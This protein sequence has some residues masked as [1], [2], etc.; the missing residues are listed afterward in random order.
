MAIKTNV[1]TTIEET[2]MLEKDTKLLN[3]IIEDYNLNN[4]TP[5]DLLERANRLQE[6]FTLCK[7]LE[8]IK[9]DS[10]IDNETFTKIVS[11][12]NNNEI[13]VETVT[14]YQSRI[15]EY[16]IPR[17]KYIKD[18]RKVKAL[19]SITNPS[20]RLFIVASFRNSKYI[21]EYL[22]EFPRDDDTYFVIASYTSDQDLIVDMFKKIKLSTFKNY[23][24]RN[25]DEEHKKEVL[26]NIDNINLFIGALTRIK[27]DEFKLQ[28]LKREN[29]SYQKAIRIIISIEDET[30]RRATLEKYYKI[31]GKEIYTGGYSKNYRFYLGGKDALPSSLSF[32]VELEIVGKNAGAILAY[33]GHLLGKHPVKEEESI[34]DGVEIA[35]SILHFNRQDIN[36]IYEICDFAHRNGLEVDLRC[37]G[38]IHFGIDLLNGYDAWYFLFYIYTRVEHILYLI[39]NERGDLPRDNVDAFAQPISAKY[40]G[41]LQEIRSFKTP[42]EFI[43]IIQKESEDKGEGINLN[44]IG[45]RQDTIEFR[46]PN[47][48]INPRIITENVLLFGNLIVLASKLSRL[49]LDANTYTLLMELDDDAKSE[50]ERLDVLLK[51]LF[52][53]PHNRET[54]KRRYTRNKKLFD[55]YYHENDYNE[56]NFTLKSEH[57]II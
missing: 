6:D 8:F 13:L 57:I 22:D 42:Q 31:V 12:I 19:E 7:L 5:R 39:S 29:I 4:I 18:N 25:L 35:S 38:H 55:K 17:L 26:N 40:K 48:S 3:E 9:D 54:F 10:N 37:G 27:D 11:R 32:G 43:H 53:E 14:K 52:K 47:G 56:E 46:I 1:C 23:L 44:N 30:L 20:T 51:M 34:K 21:R 45:K 24:F 16:I 36:E 28:L 41:L 2:E 15:S 50:E 33:G 49:P